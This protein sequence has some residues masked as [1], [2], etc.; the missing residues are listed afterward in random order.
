MHGQGHIIIFQ[1]HRRAI[2]VQA[3]DVL[4]AGRHDLGWDNIKIEVLEIAVVEGIMFI[5]LRRSI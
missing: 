5:V 2:I 4:G 3:D 1:M